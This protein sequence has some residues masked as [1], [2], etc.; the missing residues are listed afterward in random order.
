MATAIEQFLSAASKPIED[1]LSQLVSGLEGGAKVGFELA[2]AKADLDMKKQELALRNEQISSDFITKGLNVAAQAG[3]IKNAGLRNK[4]FNLAMQ[5]LSNGGLKINGLTA[6]VAFDDEE[7]RNYFYD[8]VAKNPDSAEAADWARAMQMDPDNFK[9]W[10]AQYKL[11]QAEASGAAMKSGFIEGL[12]Q[13]GRTELEILKAEQDAKAAAEVS[14]QALSKDLTI[15]RQLLRRVAIGP[16]GKIRSAQEQVGILQGY[17]ASFLNQINDIRA[18]I[19]KL[20]R[21]DESKIDLVTNNLQEAE[22]NLGVNDEA[23]SA[24]IGRAEK[25]LGAII[26]APKKA[27]PKAPKTSQ[28][29]AKDLGSIREQAQK[30][31]KDDKQMIKSLDTVIRYADRPGP[32]SA[33]L[34]IGAMD[35]IRSNK[36][37]VLREGD[38]DRALSTQGVLDK[39]EAFVKKY[40][41]RKGEVLGSEAR[42]EY[43]AIAQEY[44]DVVSRVVADSYNTYIEQGRGIGAS[45]DQI[46]RIVVDKS[47]WPY[48]FPSQKPPQERKVAPKV[49][50]G[51]RPTPS[52]TATL[53]KGKPKQALIDKS[54]AKFPNDWKMR[55]QAIGYDVGGL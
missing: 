15:P 2:K 29:I 31:V 49:D 40:S 28:E 51:F 9:E 54:K 18:T 13:S 52:G 5:N 32:V 23:A 34:V 20:D 43:K 25:F 3:K 26:A 50:T 22:Q 53:G 19:R 17:R 46:K 6:E 45:D 41:T 30:Y 21:G 27:T 1:P 7:A 14:L 33:G 12:K 10:F 42:A 48:I 38:Y 11:K 4:L 47:L 39:V 8:R 16:N 35:A 55:L 24:A 37:N 44:K 36:I